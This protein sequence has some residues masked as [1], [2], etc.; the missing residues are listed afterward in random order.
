MA[1]SMDIETLNITIIGASHLPLTF[2]KREPKA[3]IELKTRNITCQTLPMQRPSTEPRW[4]HDREFTFPSLNRDTMVTFSVF[5]KGFAFKE[6]LGRAE[7]SVSELL[8]FGHDIEGDELIIDDKKGRATSAELIVRVAASSLRK[9]AAS[10]VAQTQ[11]T[12]RNLLTEPTNADIASAKMV[13]EAIVE[14]EDLQTALESVLS[15][16]HPFVNLA[17]QVVS[18]GLKIIQKQRMQDLK[19]L[20][21]TTTMRDLY[22]A[23]TSDEGLQ[24]IRSVEH[25]VERV[26]IQ[27]IE[28]G[29]F[30]QHVLRQDFKDGVI[31]F[32]MS[33]TEAKI[34]RFSQ[35]FKDLRDKFD[36][37]LAVSTAIVSV[38]TLDIVQSLDR[39][40]NLESLRHVPMETHERATCLPGTRL[41]ILQSVEEWLANTTIEQR[42][43]WL[44]GLA[45][46]GKS[47]LSTTIANTLRAINRLGA[48]VYFN[49]EV[50]G[51]SDPGILIR[52]VA[53]QLAEFDDRIGIA[54]S[55]FENL[56]VRALSS[57][58]WPYGPI[59]VVIDALDECGNEQNRQTL[60]KVL[61]DGL[62]DLPSF[63]RII[64]TSRPESDITRTFET[65]PLVKWNPLDILALENRKDIATFIRYR[66]TEIQKKRKVFPSDWPGEDTIRDLT[67]RSFGLF[68]WAFTACRYLDNHDPRSK[69]QEVLEKSVVTSGPFAA[70][71]SLYETA[72]LAAGNWADMAFARFCNEL[73]GL[74]LVAKNP[75]SCS[76]IDTILCRKESSAETVDLFLCFLYRGKDDTVQSLHPSFVDYLADHELCGSKSKPWFIDKKEV[77]LQIALQCVELLDRELKENICGLTRHIILMQILVEHVSEVSDTAYIASVAEK[78]HLFLGRHL[79]HWIEAMVI[80][81]YHGEIIRLLRML[82]RWTKKLSPEFRN[83][84]QLVYDA[85]RFARYFSN[86]IQQHPLL[87]YWSALP[88]TPA[89]TSVFRTFHHDGLPQLQNPQQFWPPELQQLRGHSQPVR[90]VAFSPDG[91]KIA[92]GSDDETIRVWDSNTGN[93][94]IPPLRGHSGAVRS[95]ALSETRIVS[96]A[97]DGTIRVWDIIT[98][99]EIIGLLPI[100]GHRS[101]AV[102]SVA[103]SLD[104][105]KIVAGLVDATVRVWDI[106]SGQEILPAFKGHA[107]AVT[108]AAFSSD[109]STIVSSSHVPMNI[110]VWDTKTGRSVPHTSQENILQI[111]SKISYQSKSVW[112]EFTASHPEFAVYRFPSMTFSP[113]ATQIVAISQDGKTIRVWDANTGLEALP[114][115]GGHSDWVTSLA[116]SRDGSKIL[117]G[118]VDKT[119]R[120]WEAN[121]SV[122][123]AKASDISSSDLEDRVVL[124]VAFSPDGTKIV[125]SSRD[126][127]IVVWDIKT[128]TTVASLPPLQG[129]RIANSDDVTSVA[130]L[131][132]DGKKIV[133]AACNDTTIRVW[134]AKTGSDV[135]PPIAAHSRGVISIACSPDG[136]KIVSGSLDKTDT[137]NPRAVCA[138]FS[139]DTTKFL[140]SCERNAYI[141]DANTGEEIAPA[142]TSHVNG[143]VKNDWVKFIAVSHDG[144]KVALGSG[145]PL[146]CIWDLSNRDVLP[147]MIAHPFDVHS[148]GFSPDGTKIASASGGRIYIMD[149]NTASSR[150]P[151]PASQ[152][153]SL[154]GDGWLIDTVTGVFLTKIY[155]E[156]P[157]LDYWLSHGSIFVGWISGDKPPLEIHF[158]D[159]PEPE[160]V[161][162]QARDSLG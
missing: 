76:A 70:L 129:N 118:S 7:R 26:L 99:K 47:A 147:K 88:F 152:R 31:G 21:L 36:R 18:V 57:V 92:S 42:A 67:E 75:I 89:R 78:L 153:I 83:F 6:F 43:F 161:D 82:L 148:A 62:T 91:S 46:I 37:G 50:Q 135:V 64:F 131:P 52:T 101:Y 35:A 25:V 108:Y 41:E 126:E 102:L 104:G 109:G 156:L 103:L 56:L 90:A 96:A 157:K 45:G 138:A 134:D 122:S 87:V 13:A 159:L 32:L 160:S 143:W 4:E 9:Q 33:T 11:N 123:Q 115:F 113:D 58:T 20:G 1:N 29:Y 77:T 71:S 8:D 15:K 49:R 128:G 51:M 140:S 137:Y 66:T 142:L 158:P 155:A 28:C 125:S 27:T 119:V 100:G 53:F 85:W 151:S 110:C 48:F 19:L 69:L 81:D 39:T 139:P 17:W 114:P 117:S 133:S 24:K 68:Q 124:S 98:G 127:A 121:P 95:V 93:E 107:N 74:I 34:E 79:L 112:D 65:H 120:V 162:I 10:I 40:R 5:R 111:G 44:S 145:N 23:V 146:L 59:A 144:S 3:F 154:N 141:L 16:L 30:I 63:I 130:F 105:S 132:R 72:I 84:Q 54:I 14:N 116:F 149:T 80:L 94:I 106:N 22:S 136:S 86:T 12:K 97:T 150:Q 60:L 73:L 38:H 61:S 55:S 2:S